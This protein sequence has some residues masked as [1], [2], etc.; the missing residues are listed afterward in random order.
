MRQGVFASPTVDPIGTMIFV[1]QVYGGTY[2][3]NATS[4]KIIWIYNATY[5]TGTY[6]QWG[7]TNYNAVLY[8]DGL[9]YFN[10]YY[11]I[12]CVDAKTGN[13]TWNL[14]LGREDIAG[15][16]SYS[17]GKIYVVSETGNLYSVNAMNGVKL[18]YYPTSCLMHAI[19]VPYNGSLYLA[20][21]N[22]KLYRFGDTVASPSTEPE[23]TPATSPE[24]IAT[25]E[26]TATAESTATPAP[27]TAPTQSTTTTPSDTQQPSAS[28]QSPS[29]VLSNEVLI[30]IG[31]VI[32]IIIIIAAVL[33]LR[34]RK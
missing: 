6:T 31:A 8:V 32:V 4:G 24:P 22:W 17:Y 30:S 25:T 7:T 29:S 21:T 2:C 10:D 27:T 16:I 20:A 26:P 1:R 18:S 28:P 9:C 34:K 19:P 15:G 23:T 33:L 13:V 11:S 5:N 3:I 14:Y 12:V